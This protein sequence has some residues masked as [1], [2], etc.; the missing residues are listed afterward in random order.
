MMVSYIIFKNICSYKQPSLLLKEC[1]N[2][3]IKDHSAVPLTLA[4]EAAE[5]I[6]VTQY[7]ALMQTK[8]HVKRKIPYSKSKVI[9]NSELA[10][11]LTLKF[12]R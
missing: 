6:H 3:L 5:L 7:K 9:L 10:E 8:K 2:F 1:S 12:Q 4:L 11:I